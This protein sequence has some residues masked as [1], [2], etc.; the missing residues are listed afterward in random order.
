MNQQIYC[1]NEVIYKYD[2]KGDGF[3]WPLSLVYKIL[4]QKL[5]HNMQRHSTQPWNCFIL[6][7]RRDQSLET[8]REDFS[9]MSNH[10]NQLYEHWLSRIVSK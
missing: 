6:F 7:A 4:Y 3:L 5:W 1:I 2:L 10:M 9:F 8:I